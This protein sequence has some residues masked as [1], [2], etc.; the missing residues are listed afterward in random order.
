MA[1]QRCFRLSIPANTTTRRANQSMATSPPRRTITVG[2]LQETY[3]PWERRAPLTPTQVHT[4]LQQYNTQ[5]KIL[6]QPSSLRAFANQDYQQAGATITPNLEN[7]NIILGVKRPSEEHTLLPNKCYAFFSHTVKGQTENLPLLRTCL[8]RNIQLL[9][10]ERILQED[11]HRFVSFGRYAGIAGALDGLHGLGQ[12]LLYRHQR[13]TP[14]LTLPRAIWHTSLQQSL[15]QLQ[16]AVEEWKDALPEPLVMTIT[17][18]GGSVHEGVMS[19]LEQLPHETV[20]VN[21]LPELWK[22]PTQ[23]GLYLCPVGTADVMRHKDANKTFDRQD[24]AAHP[25]QYESIFASHIAPYTQ[26]VWNCIYWDA[27]YPRLMTKRDA[28]KLWEEGKDRYVRSL[29]GKIGETR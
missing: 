21:E 3:H 14:L 20:T 13:A 2:I 8:A 19:V 1:V 9:D 25:S 15:D 16:Q 11:G 10:Y 27:R 7:A 5:L 17:G 12:C 6:V 28:R 4:L 26:A 29:R 24:Y 18:K 23:S 22:N